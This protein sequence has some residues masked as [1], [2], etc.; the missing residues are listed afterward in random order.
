LAGNSFEV[1]LTNVMRQSFP[2][3]AAVKFDQTNEYQLLSGVGVS[4]A[5]TSQIPPSTPVIIQMAFA[6]TSATKHCSP[7]VL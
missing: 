3:S 4:F 2:L 5:S 1:P 7:L 6:S